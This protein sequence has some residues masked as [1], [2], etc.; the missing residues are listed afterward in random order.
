MITIFTNCGKL[1]NIRI[2]K[3]SDNSELNE[4]DLLTIIGEKP[5]TKLEFESDIVYDK[6]TKVNAVTTPYLN[7][8]AIRGN[9]SNKEVK[10]IQL[11]TNLYFKNKWGFIKNAVDTNGSYHDVTKI[12]T[13]TSCS[14]SG[15]TL[16]ETIGIDLSLDFLKKNQNLSLNKVIIFHQNTAKHSHNKP[17]N[18]CS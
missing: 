14:N 7:N 10:F 6:F 2:I 9:F 3:N 11:Y 13:D 8:M 15:C 17:F 18:N 16:T 12:S 5:L 1:R 4:K